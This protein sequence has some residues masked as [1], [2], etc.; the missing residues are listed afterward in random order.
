MS[1]L[2]FLAPQQE[3]TAVLG[4]KSKR[5]SLFLLGMPLQRAFTPGLS[6]PDHAFLA[7]EQ[8]AQQ[9]QGPRRP[10]RVDKRFP[11]GHAATALPLP[12]PL[13]INKSV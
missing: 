12:G 11:A 6:T 8:A 7:G 4:P 2:L 13:S 1:L 3:G 5:M 9:Q 10:E